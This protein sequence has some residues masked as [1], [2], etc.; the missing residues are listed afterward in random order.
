ML[1]KILLWGVGILSLVPLSVV[2]A[3]TT[4]V[5]SGEN[6]SVIGPQTVSVN[7][8][9][10]IPATSRVVY[11][12]VAQAILAGAGAPQYGYASTTAEV[13][14]PTTNHQ[15]AIG[16]LP[17]GGMTYFRPVSGDGS[18]MVAGKE[19][20]ID[21]SLLAGSCTYL[22]GYLK[23]GDLNDP[24]EVKKLQAFLRGV[25]KNTSVSVTG[26]FDDA[27]R[28]AVIAFQEKYKDDVLVPW[29]IETGTGYVYI[30]TKQK[31]NE[32]FCSTPIALTAEEK[33]IINAGRSGGVPT[34]KMGRANGSDTQNSSLAEGLDLATGTAALSAD[35]AGASGESVSGKLSAAV[36]N[37]KDFFSRNQLLV[38]IVFVIAFI[39]IY[40]SRNKKE[41]DVTQTKLLKGK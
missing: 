7:W 36:G 26:I 1:K 14:T 34:S 3:D 29:G 18:S 40:L 5:I 37:M 30:T 31:I 9:T 32:L 24:S 16:P 38:L 2:S 41:E 23:Q 6:V 22:A 21:S 17:S 13:I 20:S 35:S 10:N 27:T 15:V 39:A 25:E 11:G 12:P 33:A 19:V 28:N 4:L 8:T